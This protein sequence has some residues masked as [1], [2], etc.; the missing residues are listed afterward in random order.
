MEGGYEQ[1]I[2]EEVN[3][4]N[5]ARE[6]YTTSTEVGPGPV[7]CRGGMAGASIRD[8][9]GDWS[10][11][12]GQGTAPLQMAPDVRLDVGVLRRSVH[13]SPDEGPHSVSSVRYIQPTFCS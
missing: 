6:I 4:F 12:F 9:N 3:E 5:G 7:R 2:T 1:G 13:M 11:R 8:S 10:L